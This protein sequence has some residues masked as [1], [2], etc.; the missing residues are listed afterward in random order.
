MA[1]TV[2]QLVDDVGDKAAR[3]E[4]A[5]RAKDG[6][7]TSIS[8][9]LRTPLTG[10]QSTAE[11]LQQFGDEASPAERV[12]FVATILCEAERLGQRISD[13]LDYA[14]LAGGTAEW[15]IGRVELH[16]CCE[17][18]CRRLASLQQLKP[19][20]FRF[21][22]LDEALLYGDR[23]HITQA[24]RHLAHNAWTWSP[25][26]GTVDIAVQSIADGIADGF[27]VEV[28]DRGPGIAPAERARVFERFA[29]GGD[30][31][32]DKPAGIGIGLKIVAE[33]AAMHGGTIDYADRAGG[34]ACFRFALRTAD[35]PIDRLKSDLPS[36][37]TFV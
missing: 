21:A 33:V 15:T 2:Q 14:A 27:V 7:L 24:I 23:E 9:E 37:A 35:R 13:A 11:L 4:A 3:A 34:G 32:V 18:A 17:Q 19:V 5:N 12:D 22:G 25:S 36:V 26:G 1:E 30:V 8:H 10:I 29:Q 6:F 16:Y 20:A 28:A 31:L